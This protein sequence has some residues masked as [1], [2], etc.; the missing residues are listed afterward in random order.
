MFENEPYHTTLDIQRNYLMCYK[1]RVHVKHPI[2][3]H[4]HRRFHTTISI[5]TAFVEIRTN[6]VWLLKW[7]GGGAK[8]VS[9]IDV[10]L[11]LA[12]K[13]VYI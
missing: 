12:V 4:A 3:H 6:N 7:R 8:G 11:A 13:C 2:I 9:N 5:T 10:S 1:D